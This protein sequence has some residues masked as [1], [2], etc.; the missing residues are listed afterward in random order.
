LKAIVYTKYGPPEVLSQRDGFPQI[1]EVEKPVPKENEVLIKIFAT[2]VNRT[3]WN[4]DLFTR[5]K[6]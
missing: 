6:K 4:Y 2:T 5:N 1:K 3:D